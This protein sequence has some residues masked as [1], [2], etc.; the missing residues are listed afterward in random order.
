MNIHDMTCQIP[1]DTFRALI[2]DNKEQIE[3]THDR[4]RHSNILSQRLS[5]II[6]PTNGIGSGENTRSRVQSGLNASLGYGNSL[7]FHRFVNSDLV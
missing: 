3:P 5:T 6:S 4:R 2:Q 7:L 1:I